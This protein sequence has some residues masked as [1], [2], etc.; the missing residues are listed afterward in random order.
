[1]NSPPA[2]DIGDVVQ[3]RANVETIGIV[4]GIVRR[5]AGWTYL[6][7]WPETGEHEHYS[8][9]IELHTPATA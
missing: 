6:V 3:L 7:A 2:F 8:C 9:E 1:M 5:E 4:T